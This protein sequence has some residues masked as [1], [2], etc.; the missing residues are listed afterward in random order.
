MLVFYSYTRLLFFLRK[1]NLSILQLPIYRTVLML[2]DIV[3]QILQTR[4]VVLDKRLRVFS[5]GKADNIAV[6]G[7]VKA[8]YARQSDHSRTL[9]QDVRI[10]LVVA[11]M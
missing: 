3:F 5:N 2:P 1:V 8:D 11:S 6:L 10:I 9:Q 7:F 4:L